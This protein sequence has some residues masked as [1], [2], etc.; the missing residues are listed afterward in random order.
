MHSVVV[1]LLLE[2]LGTSPEPIWIKMG[3]IPEMNA[4]IGGTV[5]AITSPMIE[6]ILSFSTGGDINGKYNTPTLLQVGDASRLGGSNREWIFRDEQLQQTVQVAV[7]SSN[8]ITEQRFRTPDPY[9]KK[10]QFWRI[11]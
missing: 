3:L 4:T 5:T 2:W 9:P 11:E 1:R 6:S 7:A 8:R 10:Q